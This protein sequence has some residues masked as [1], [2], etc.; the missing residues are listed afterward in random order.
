MKNKYLNGARITEGKFREILKYFCEDETV[1]KAAKYS[2]INRN[3]VNRIYNL[4]RVR[5]VKN[6]FIRETWIRRIW[7]RWKFLWSETNTWKKRTRSGRKNAGIWDIKTRRESL[8]DGR[9]EMFK[10]TAH[11]NHRRINHSHRWLE[12]LRWA[13]FKWLWPLPSLSLKEW[14][15]SW[16]ISYKWDWILLELCQKKTF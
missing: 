14:I 16:K 1:T 3:T 5:I 11:A 12:S 9:Q 13:Y 8:C 10:G 15:C 6:K 2:R 4:L 7:V